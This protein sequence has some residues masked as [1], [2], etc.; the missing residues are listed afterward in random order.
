MSKLKKKGG[1][2]AEIAD[3]KDIVNELVDTQVD[4]MKEMCLAAQ[5]IVKNLNSFADD[6]K[7][8]KTKLDREY[9][10]LQGVLE[11][12]KGSFFPPVE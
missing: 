5:N 3:Q 10:G 8:D 2:P 12:Y 4:T 7:T 1:S 11:K 9:K 6:T